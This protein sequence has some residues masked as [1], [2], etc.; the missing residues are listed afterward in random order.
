MKIEKNVMKQLI[1]DG[2]ISIFLYALPI[3]LMFLYYYAKGERPWKEQPGK[4]ASVNQS[5]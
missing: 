2:A 5:K 4:A 3:A 1:R